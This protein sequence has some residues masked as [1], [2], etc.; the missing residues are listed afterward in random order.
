[1]KGQKV[2]KTKLLTYFWYILCKDN[3]CYSLKVW[4]SVSPGRKHGQ[5]Q[6]GA[7]MMTGAPLKKQVLSR[8][9]GMC[10]RRTQ[11]ALLGA[12][13]FKQGEVH[14][15][16]R[17][18]PLSIASSTR[19]QGYSSWAGAGSCQIKKP[20]DFWTKKVNIFTNKYIVCHKG[21]KSTLYTSYG[22][23]DQMISLFRNIFI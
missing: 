2:F 8:A 11:A 13:L 14:V 10:E 20:I 18:W 1:M 17:W 5:L 16:D 7:D 19:G 12:P 23:F 6:F 21:F 4:N 9:V 15:L 22:F 3:I